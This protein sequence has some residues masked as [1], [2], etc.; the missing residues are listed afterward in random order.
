MNP[1]W[2]TVLLIFVS[3]VTGASFYN[4]IKRPKLSVIAGGSGGGGPD[5]MRNEMAIAN[6]PGIL[7]I[8]LGETLIFN[9]RI[10]PP[11]CKGLSVDRNTARACRAWLLEMP[12]KRPITTLWWQVEDRMVQTVNLDTGG[13]ANLML[14]A[15]RVDEPLTYFVY[16]PESPRSPSPMIPDDDVKFRDTREFLIRITYSDGQQQLD[17]PIT[18]RKGNHGRFSWEH[19]GGGGGL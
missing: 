2:L 13:S 9:K 1:I 5:Y 16:Q 4:H 19:N 3:V 14:F 7:G 10:L 15:R 18:M 11:L 17:A 6:R 8:N 12:S